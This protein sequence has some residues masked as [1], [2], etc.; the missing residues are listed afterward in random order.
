MDDN[1]TQVNSMIIIFAI[2]ILSVL[3]NIYAINVLTDYKNK[4][5]RPYCFPLGDKN[6]TEERLEENEKCHK[7]KEEKMALIKKYDFNRHI[8][9]LGIG[10]AC[11]FFAIIINNS[12]IKTGLGTSGLFTL[13]YGSLLY[14]SYY[15]DKARLG[16]ISTGFI[17]MLY[18]ASRVFSMRDFKGDYNYFDITFLIPGFQ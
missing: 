18:I 3:F 4:P 17:L 9:L 14:W 6:L 15:D 8:G 12:Y 10:F 11:I 1:S 7:E 13:L 2:I 5:N 16:I